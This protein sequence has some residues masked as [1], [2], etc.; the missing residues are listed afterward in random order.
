MN[1]FLPVDREHDLAKPISIQKCLPEGHLARYIVE[2]VE[3][4]DLSHF[5]QSYAGRGQEAYP[6]AMLL[7]LL[8]Y[9]YA[10]GIF[11]SRKIERATYESIPFRYIACN[12]HPDHDT[13]ATFR[14]RFKKEFEEIFVQVLRVAQETGVG[15]FGTV[16]L[17]GAKIHANA[18]RHSALSYAHAQQLEA[19]IKAEVAELL[20]KAEEA[21][22]IPEGMNLPEEIQRREDRLAAIASAK[23]K[24]SSP[25]ARAF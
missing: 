16:S 13:L 6:P 11:A 18:S 4:L 17:D 22:A 24:I 20:K 23:Q 5:E 8:I 2:I 9:A 19:K 7:A 14:K 3:S 21:T 10:T 25:C 1:H 15:R 12:L